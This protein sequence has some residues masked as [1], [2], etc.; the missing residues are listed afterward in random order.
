MQVLGG[1][2]KLMQLSECESEAVQRTLLETQNSLATAL[3]RVEAHK[4]RERFLYR[5]NQ[6]LRGALLQAGLSPVQL[7]DVVQSAVSAVK[8][9][10]DP[11]HLG[12]FEAPAATPVPGTV[13]ED[14]LRIAPLS[15]SH[16]V[17]YFTP[18]GKVW[19]R[20]SCHLHSPVGLCAPL[21]LAGLAGQTC[22]VCT[23]KKTS[24]STCLTFIV[25]NDKDESL[26]F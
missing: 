20:A 19:P 22:H 5:E 24:C 16:P 4:C 8:D 10:G 13:A 26:Q 18:D 23:Q 17:H 11:H 25:R 1:V 21:C 3:A 6:A 9:V 2:E 15:A 12:A 7:Q 14:V